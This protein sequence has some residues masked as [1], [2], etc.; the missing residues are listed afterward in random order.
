MNTPE[1]VEHDEYEQINHH[2]AHDNVGRI[3]KSR[4]DREQ[5]QVE[6]QYAQLNAH[7]GALVHDV[8]MINK[9]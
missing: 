8:H 2:K 3:S 1:R 6:A 4:F 7:K 5:R 9:L